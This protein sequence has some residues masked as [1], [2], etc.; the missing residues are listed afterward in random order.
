MNI[1]Y[2]MRKGLGLVRRHYTVLLS[3]AAVAGVPVTAVLAVKGHERY[4]KT[5]D[6]KEYA[7]AVLTGLASMGF[8]IFCE[9]THIERENAFILAHNLLSENFT[10]YKAS[11][12]KIFG[13]AAGAKILTDVSENADEYEDYTKTTE[14]ETLH[15]FYDEYLGIWFKDS[16]YN[17]F[18]ANLALQEQY[19]SEGI[20]EVAYYY[21]ALD[22]PYHGPVSLAFDMETLQVDY[23]CMVG[24]P[25]D[26]PEIKRPDGE[27]GYAIEWP[28]QPEIVEWLE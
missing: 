2:L 27:I 5:K 4:Q 15:W 7:P 23:E 8:I 24:V 20:G 14:D 3:A 6:K 1:K 12:L 26:Y 18:L 16:W 9:K 17:V 10:D 13:P 28:I 22:L 11:A 19:T 21:Q 25:F